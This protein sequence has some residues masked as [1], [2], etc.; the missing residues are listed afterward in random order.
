M[1]GRGGRLAELADLTFR[2]ESDTT[3]R[4]QEVHITLGHMLCNLVDRI[5]FPDQFK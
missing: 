5:L 4:I 3:A 1:T 2:V